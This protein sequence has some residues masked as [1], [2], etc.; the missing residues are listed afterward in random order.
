MSPIINTSRR[1]PRMHVC[2]KSGGTNLNLW[3]VIAEKP[4]FLELWVQMTKITLKVN[5]NNPQFQYRQRDPMTYVCLVRIWWLKLKFVMIYHA[6]NVKF[7]DRCRQRQYHY[8][9]K[10]Q[11]VKLYF[12]Y[13]SWNHYHYC[14]TISN[15]KV[16]F[17][18]DIININLIIMS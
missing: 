15:E 14:V 9:L 12:V 4:N 5:V 6:D 3:R 17:L 2:S 1:Y 10:W 11:R 7:A 16:L 13:E 8:G 18:Q